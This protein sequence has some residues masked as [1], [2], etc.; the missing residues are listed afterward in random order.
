MT[1]I[2]ARRADGRPRLVYVR[3]FA[4]VSVWPSNTSMDGEP[5]AVSCSCRTVCHAVFRAFVVVLSRRYFTLPKNRPS[6]VIGTGNCLTTFSVFGSSTLTWPEYAVRY[7][8][9]FTGLT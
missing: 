8:R 2:V 5:A 7:T 6:G 1:P 4:D 3:S 9:P